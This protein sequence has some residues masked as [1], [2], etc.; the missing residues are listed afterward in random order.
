MPSIL[1]LGPVDI[2]P[3][4]LYVLL[5]DVLQLSCS[6]EEHL[7]TPALFCFG[8]YRLNPMF[9]TTAHLKF[10]VKCLFQESNNG[11]VV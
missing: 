7:Q 10:V 2:K 8:L 6:L 3:S 5:P 4:S 11:F 1:E 9:V